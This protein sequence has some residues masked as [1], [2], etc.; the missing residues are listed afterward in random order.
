M[1]EP[2][3]M[4]TISE[5]NELLKGAGNSNNSQS[6]TVIVNIP[7]TGWSDTMPYKFSINVDGVAENQSPMFYLITA[8]ETATQEE[9]DAINLIT[10]IYT[11]ANIIHIEASQIPSTN[12][13][14]ALCGLSND[15]DFSLAD[16]T[17]LINRVNEAENA[18][19]EAEETVRG[20]ET[21][22]EE[23]VTRIENLDITVD[24]FTGATAEAAGTSGT[25]PAPQ[26][27]DEN[28]VLKGDGTWGD[29]SI[30]VDDTL[31]IEGAAA[32]AKKVGSKINS[33]Q[34][35]VS[36]AL[37]IQDLPHNIINMDLDA[38]I[39]PSQFSNS[40]IVYGDNKYVAVGRTHFTTSVDGVN[41]DTPSRLIHEGTYTA[42]AYGNNKFV[43]LSNRNRYQ[44]PVVIYTEDCVN[45]EYV[46]LPTPR[47]LVPWSNIIFANGIFVVMAEFS[48][49]GLI[50]TAYSP[51]GINWSL[52]N[53]FTFPYDQGPAIWGQESMENSDI[54]YFN[55]QFIILSRD[56]I[57]YQVDTEPDQRRIL[58][59]G[60]CSSDCV[61]WNECSYEIKVALSV[62]EEHD[63]RSFMAGV[64]CSDNKLIAF[65]D[66]G[67]YF[68]SSDGLTWEFAT[69][70]L[71]FYPFPN[72]IES[73]R[74]ANTIYDD[75]CNMF[76]ILSAQEYVDED[77]YW[78]PG[79]WMQSADGETWSIN[80]YSQLFRGLHLVQ[81]ADKILIQYSNFFTFSY[82]DVNWE[83]EIPMLVNGDGENK[84]KDAQAVLG[85]NELQNQLEAKEAEIAELK[86]QLAELNGK[87]GVDA[88][89]VVSSLPSDAASHPNT[90][91]LVTGA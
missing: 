1:G 55:N 27:G 84:A 58:I 42:G 18:L 75:R 73:H 56:A 54:V 9:I 89:K 11:E 34:S 87:M 59:A 24:D 72:R 45:W 86:V 70:P 79:V 37:T 67:S 25:V 80:P 23:A 69:Q 76:K 43:F 35:S 44:L 53:P 26:A 74:I 83:F 30:T 61:T 40:Y 14:I 52:S 65:T 5:Y 90:L 12:F 28:K 48:G 2:I 31:K 68:V 6:E 21:A 38:Q 66:S 8:G 33:L 32:D 78:Y 49:G 46:T 50:P 81:G 16:Y 63:Y 85:I 47:I 13:S 88:I 29:V 82:D 60:L 17:V 41:W 64:V 20:A 10:A 51:D 71:P 57:D 4:L 19:R 62:F 22:L 91:Y 15:V 3:R 36:Y 77:G 39:D 7:T